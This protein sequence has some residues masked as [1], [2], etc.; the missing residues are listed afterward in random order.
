MA[1]TKDLI[2]TVNPNVCLPVTLNTDWYGL[3]TTIQFTV[4]SIRQRQ[5]DL[6]VPLLAKAFIRLFLYK[7]ANSNNALV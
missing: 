6:G 4:R 2:N 1:I 3:N 5:S 7:M